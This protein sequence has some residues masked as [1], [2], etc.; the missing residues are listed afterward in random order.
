MAVGADGGSTLSIQAEQRSV[1]MTM[2]LIV[3]F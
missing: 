3:T 1:R 2:N